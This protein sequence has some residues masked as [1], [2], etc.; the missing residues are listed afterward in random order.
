[1]TNIYTTEPFMH[2]IPI[3]HSNITE[4]FS[5]ET[6]FAD[7]LKDYKEIKGGVLTKDLHFRYTCNKYQEEGRKVAY[8]VV[9][10]VDMA[11]GLLWVNGYSP[12]GKHQYP[13]WKRGTPKNPMILAPIFSKFPFSASPFLVHGLG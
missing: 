7:K 12:D 10:K 9:Q 2:S 13:D 3:M 8:G 11:E 6:V 1:V 5:D 4:F